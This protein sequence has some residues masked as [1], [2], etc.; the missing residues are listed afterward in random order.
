MGILW[1]N[2][3]VVSHCPLY[4][5]TRILEE[6]TQEIYSVLVDGPANAVVECII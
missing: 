3:F 5:I 1:P 4:V 2:L 6:Y